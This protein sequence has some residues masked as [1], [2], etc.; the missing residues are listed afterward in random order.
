MAE[1]IMFDVYYH[2]GPKDGKNE[3]VR[4][5]TVDAAANKTRPG[6]PRYVMDK[7]MSD[8][9]GGIHVKWTTN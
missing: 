9:F 2:G 1:E 4:A 5:S 7:A 3:K 6:E 8:R